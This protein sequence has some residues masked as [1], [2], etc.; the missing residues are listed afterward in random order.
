MSQIRIYIENQIKKNEYIILSKNQ[1]HYLKNVMRR[2]SGD[3]VVV[4]NGMEE[5]SSICDV[6]NKFSIKPIELLRKKKKI[7]DIWICFSL[8]KSRNIDFLMEKTS[9]IGVTRFVPMKTKYSETTKLNYE[10]LKRISIEAIEQSNSLNLPIIEGLRNFKDILNEW[11]DER[12]I[13]FCDEKGGYPV[14]KFIDLSKKKSKYAIFIGPVGGWHEYERQALINKKSLHINFGEN[15][16]KADTAAIFCL[17][18]LK[19]IML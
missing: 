17:S 7:K 10:R 4:F 2:K 5:W 16:L 6:G 14:S 19:S 15:I 12:I 8:I 18:C 9:E 1:A 3:S 13:I 11:D